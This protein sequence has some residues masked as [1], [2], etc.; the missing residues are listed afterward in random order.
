MAHA[1]TI[2]Q[3]ARR[4]GTSIRSLRKYDSLGLVYGLG[5]SESNYRLFDESSLWC[6]EIIRRLHSLGLTLNEIQ[7]ITA[8]YVGDSGTRLGP[9]LGEILELALDR[10]DSRIKQLQETRR[11]INGFRSAQAAALAGD[12]ELDLSAG[13]PRSKRFGVAS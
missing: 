1:M 3:L 10:I 12:A 11:S 6:L 5:R 4:S 9:R 2:G 13:R 7:Q 8:A